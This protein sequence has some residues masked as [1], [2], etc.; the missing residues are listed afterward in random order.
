METVTGLI[1]TWWS[2]TIHNFRNT[3]SK[4]E[5]KSRYE[6]LMNDIIRSGINQGAD[7]VGNAGQQPH[8]QSEKSGRLHY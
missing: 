3:P 5:G 6:H 4:A 2:S 1:T 7:V 8:E